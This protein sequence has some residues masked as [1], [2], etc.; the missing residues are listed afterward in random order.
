MV[1]ISKLILHLLMGHVYLRQICFFHLCL[2]HLSSN[3]L[4]QDSLA[5]L[6]V[7]TQLTLQ[8][9]ENKAV[10]SESDLQLPVCNIKS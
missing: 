1:P 7:I 4:V 2:D 5:T 8:L 3:V 10:Q 6:N 9:P